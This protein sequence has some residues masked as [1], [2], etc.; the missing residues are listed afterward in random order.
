MKKRKIKKLEISKE[1]ITI[2]SRDEG[3]RILGG[4][5]S[6]HMY[7]NLCVQTLTDYDTDCNGGNVTATCGGSTIADTQLCNLSSGG[8]CFTDWYGSC[9]S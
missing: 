1:D 2:L 4:Q 9:R 3:Q 8:N 5:M 6:D 7:G